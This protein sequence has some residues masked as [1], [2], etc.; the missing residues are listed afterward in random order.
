MDGNVA[1]EKF[2]QA[3]ELAREGR[4][5]ES[6]RVLYELNEA[7]PKNQKILFPIAQNLANAGR[8]DDALAVCSNLIA[9]FSDEKAA[10]LKRQIEA[11][12]RESQSPTPDDDFASIEGLDGMGGMGLDDILGPSSSTSTAPIQV[13]NSVEW[14]KWA[15]GA[16][17]IV[18]VVVL[19]G[20]GVLA[21]GNTDFESGEGVESNGEMGITIGIYVVAWFIG[22]IWHIGV[23]FMTLLVI[24]GLPEDTFFDNIKHISRVSFIFMMISLIPVLG[25]I[26]ALIYFVKVYDI[27]F[28]GCLVYVIVIW[29]SVMLFAFLIS[30]ILAV[31]VGTIEGRTP[32]DVPYEIV[33]L[34]ENAD[35]DL[36]SAELFS[37]SSSPLWEALS[38][39][40]Y[41]RV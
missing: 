40:G 26:A 36:H 33:V 35:Q 39:S 9:M 15:L 7:F 21:L 1:K 14:W 4:Y 41:Y 31:L 28:G 29:L 13:E 18:A 8:F 12:V 19:I 34:A 10:Q 16:L 3:D 23:S 6:L 17:G 24:K 32:A 20:V 30:G 22:Y 5:D 38:N 2:K 27:S 11:K 37:E 25:G